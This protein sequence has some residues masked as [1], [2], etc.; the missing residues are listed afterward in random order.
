M[1]QDK[2][3]LAVINNQFLYLYQILKNALSLFLAVA[4]LF[5]VLLFVGLWFNSP[6]AVK[7]VVSGFDLDYI[8]VFGVFIS[9]IAMSDL[10]GHTVKSIQ[11]FIQEKSANT[12]KS[13]RTFPRG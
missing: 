6:L 7:I 8:K 10:L 4:I 5:A 2:S 9:A 12:I 11:S 1:K 13:S 3:I